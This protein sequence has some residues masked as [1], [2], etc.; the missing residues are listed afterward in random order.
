MN[1]KDVIKILSKRFNTFQ[2]RLIPNTKLFGWEM[3]LALVTKT[4]Y[5]WEFEIKTDFNDLINDSKKDKWIKPYY[6]NKFNKYVKKFYYVIPQELYSK[7]NGGMIHP[8]IQKTFGLITIDNRTNYVTSKVRLKA[9]VNK[10]VNK[11]KQR[12]LNK[13]NN[14]LYFKMWKLYLK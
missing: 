13:L 7:F 10:N 5:L 8:F 12:H 3:D 11:L 4:G 1:E 9:T 2:Y 14:T 6:T